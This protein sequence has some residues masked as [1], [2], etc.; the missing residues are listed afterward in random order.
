MFRNK[1]QLLAAIVLLFMG[2]NLETSAQKITDPVLKSIL[3]A[4]ARAGE[5]KPIEKLYVQTDKPYYIVGDTIRLK[6]YL[7]NADYFTGST[8]S[9]LLYI[10]LDDENGK[11][12]KRL[13]LPVV[14]GLSWGDIPLDSAEVPKGNYTLRAYTNWIRNFDE[15][16]I[17]KKNFSVSQYE[18]N[19]LMVNTAF[20]QTEGKAEGEIK[21]SLLDGRIQ[22][23]KDIDL[24]VLN[25]KKNLVRD[26]LTTGIDGGIRFNFVL[27][28][29]KEKDAISLKARV[30]GN[31]EFTIP[32]TL[33]RID[34]TDI[35]F[36][37][38]GGTLVA[39]LPATVGIKAT[40]EDGKGI[41]IKG[42][43]FNSKGEEIAAIRTL[44]KGM[45]RFNFTAKTAETYTVKIDGIN[46]TISLP[47]VT[48]SGTIL[49]VRSDKDS[50]TVSLNGTA[51]TGTY[52]LI[53]QARGVV[54]YAEPITFVNQGKVSRVLAKSLFPTG[55]VHLTLLNSSYQPL[56]ERIVFIN[57]H[58]QLNIDVN[59][60][61]IVYGLRDSV[62][63]NVKVTDKDGK[64]VSGS[65]SV[66]VTD[67]GQVKTDSLGRN[68][69]NSLLLTSDLKGEVEDPGYYF[70]DNK[71]L[72]LDNLMLTQ[73]WIGYDWKDVTQAK[74][75]LAYLP[76]KEFIVSGK[77]SNAFGKPIEKSSV[78]LMANHPLNLIRD[79]ITDK[80]G[81]FAFKDIFPVDTA[82]F[83]VQARN[84]RNKEFNVAIEIDVVKP[85][86]F[87]AAI[88][89]QPWYVNTDTTLL[90]NMKIKTQE[91]T[92]QSIYRGEGTQ[93]K[94]VNIKA[95]KIIP[96]SKN[97]NGP[98]EADMIFDEEEM[99][100]AD[101]IS[102]L[103]LLEKKIPAFRVGPYTRHYE[104]GWQPRLRPAHVGY[105]INTQEVHFVI[106]G[107][108]L[109]RFFERMMECPPGK[110]NCYPYNDVRY[111]FIKPYLE[112]YTAED[113]KG[114][115]V[116]YSTK[117]SAGYNQ[118]F[119]S[120]QDLNIS[121]WTTEYAYIEI[122][123]RGG[124]GPFMK[125]TPGTY[126]HKTLAFTLPKQFYRPKYTVANR[127]KA[128]GT[129]MRSTIHWEPNVITDASGN[130]TFSFY[131]ADK[132][133]NYTFII[134]GADLN[135]QMGYKR[136]KLTIK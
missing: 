2:L 7:L 15:D 76:E 53:G 87:T 127:D 46:K 24:R 128:P 129:D 114:I 74:P 18:N 72:E 65:F 35:Q 109:D 123:T 113:I 97:L 84:K 17:F 75:A 73:G 82:I 12:A 1:L 38:E 77:V 14:E 62:A 40:S 57:H 100:K 81:R 122:T 112:Y 108:D 22:A 61:K 111:H 34:E 32:V 10:E 133:G 44:Y 47:T 120:I 119:L 26:K 105:I 78:I 28:E 50:L 98:G 49:S 94:E 36:M 91:N 20:K 124:R 37:P 116:H 13:M 131:S 3:N 54:C 115:E 96:G 66:A 30:K 56:N 29:D 70:N 130:A 19:P 135:G 33:N 48:A 136:R 8:R 21:L 67:D 126:L 63:V 64:P 23:F 4:T 107:L 104:K 80:E 51:T 121:G 41:N 27:P 69:F 79:T 86:Q 117:F 25:G 58:D 92:A 55:I 90:G 45:G 68:I 16:Y 110:R 134:E 5:M 132:R 11:M 39:G 99:K 9:G 103:E 95:K 60:D 93:L 89:L 31:A 59:P 102:L 52:Y 42:T 71:D 118:A 125:V 6:A 106:D 85:P 88:A 43:L 83:K 101:K